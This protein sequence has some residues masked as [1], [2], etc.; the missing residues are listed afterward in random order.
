MVPSPHSLLL[1]NRLDV[2][3]ASSLKCKHTPSKNN[4]FVTEEIASL[5]LKKMSPCYFES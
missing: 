2:T 4:S 5:H 3:K 1:T